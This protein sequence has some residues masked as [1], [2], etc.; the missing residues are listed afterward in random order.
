[1][2]GIEERIENTDRAL[3]AFRDLQTRL[4]IPA[5]ELAKAKADV[6][7]RLA[8]IQKELDRDLAAF[9]GAQDIKQFVQTHQPF[10]WLVEFY[11]IMK[12]GGFDVIIGNPPYVEYSK[13]KNDYTIRSY[14]TESCGNLY[15]F[16]TERSLALLQPDGRFGMIVPTSSI[17]TERMRSLQ[18][19]LLNIGLIHATFGF[20][21][22]KLFEGATSTNLHLSIVLAGSSIGSNPLALHHVKWNA[23]FRPYLFECLPQ[24][25]R[26]DNEILEHSRKIPR[27]ANSVHLSVLHKLSKK[28]AAKRNFAHT[29][30]NVY[31]RTTG[32][33]HYRVFTMFPTASR[34]EAIIS[35]D[36]HTHA[37]IAF[38]MYA[39]NLWNMFYYTFSNC[40]DIARYEI[41]EFPI[42][43]DRMAE[44]L[45]QNLVAIAEKLEQD[46]RKHAQIQVRHYHD[47]GDVDCYTIE[48]RESKPIIDEID[49]VLAKHYG[50]TEEELD[51]IIGSC[52]LRQALKEIRAKISI[53]FHVM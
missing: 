41:D 15:A 11:S 20:R 31:Y 27:L 8:E 49:R 16:M 6:N 18:S 25:T 24:Y 12:N 37:N 46:I 47:E 32:G 23:D 7:A 45:Q 21:P 5:S 13:V 26:T 17:S 4:G 50:F 3:H 10:H 42:G 29:N 30:N 22:A 34:K 53:P 43:L 9:Y 51:F 35:F 33:L 40:L 52:V 14:K 2:K 36:T 19:I 1:M 28:A 48:M 44:S 39:S 38:C